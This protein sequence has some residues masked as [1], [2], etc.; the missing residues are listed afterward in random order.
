MQLG[1][2]R[3]PDCGK[4]NTS[5]NSAQSLLYGADCQSIA[6]CGKGS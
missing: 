1:R 4:V 3:I 6:D 5:D 2:A